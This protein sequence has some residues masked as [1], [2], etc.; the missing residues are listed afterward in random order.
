MYRS[1][2]RGVAVPWFLHDGG[3]TRR[4]E[5]KAD[6][7]RYNKKKRTAAFRG[8]NACSFMALR[9]IKHNL[10][11]YTLIKVLLHNPVKTQGGPLKCR[12]WGKSSPPLLRASERQRDLV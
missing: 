2:I 8:R 10:R 3:N 6:P 9:V 12:H 4:E 1:V 5:S 11:L 7:A